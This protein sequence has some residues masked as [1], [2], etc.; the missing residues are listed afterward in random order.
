MQ[1]Y[2][3]QQFNHL[4]NNTLYAFNVFSIKFPQKALKT[5][6][7]KTFNSAA[8]IQITYVLFYHTFIIVKVNKQIQLSFLIVDWSYVHKKMRK[9]QFSIIKLHTKKV[10]VTQAMLYNRKMKI[11]SM[12]NFSHI[13]FYQ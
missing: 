3:V 5:T 1:K 11:F 10:S 7:K 8:L 12:I 6:A 4:N 13:L 9:K 2:H